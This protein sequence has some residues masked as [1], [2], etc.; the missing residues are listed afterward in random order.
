MSGIK[1]IPGE[2]SS[3][4]RCVRADEMRG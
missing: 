1:V 2:W 4:H 3:L